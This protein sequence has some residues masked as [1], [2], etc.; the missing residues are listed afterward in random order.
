V[1]RI[2]ERFYR[3]DKGRGRAEGGSGLGLA[4]VKHVVQA[5]GGTVEVKTEVD[6]GSTFRVVLPV[7]P[8]GRPN[9]DVESSRADGDPARSRE[10]SRLLAR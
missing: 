4:I 8:A 3:V 5:H 7:T 10:A 1:A 6:R 9:V 2:F